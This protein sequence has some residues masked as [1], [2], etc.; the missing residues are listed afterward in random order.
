MSGKNLQD[1]SVVGLMS[2]GGIACLVLS[3]LLIGCGGGGGGSGS[4]NGGGSGGLI[5]ENSKASDDPL[6]QY[7]WH[8]KNNGQY[9]FSDT[10]PVAGFDLNIGD[11][12]AS[13]VTG[14]SVKVAVIDDGIEADHEN[15]KANMQPGGVLEFCEYPCKKE[16]YGGPSEGSKYHGTA[17]AGIVGSQRGNGVGGHGVAPDVKLYDFNYLELGSYVRREMEITK[18]IPP[19]PSPLLMIQAA[20]GDHDKAKSVDVFNM[21]YGSTPDKLGDISNMLRSYSDIMKKSRNDRGGVYVKSAGNE[22]LSIGKGKE[23]LE[24]C[25]RAVDNNVTC[26]NSNFQDIHNIPEVMVVG[27]V[28]AA[29]KRSSYSNTGSSIWISGFGGEYGHEEKYNPRANNIQ[30]QPAIVTTDLTSCHKGYNGVPTD[31]PLQNAMNAGFL[32]NF[33]EWG[34]KWGG[35]HLGRFCQYS[36]TF[37]GTSASAPMVSGVVA[38]MLEANNQLNARDVKWILATTARK[39]DVHLEPV[40]NQ[41]GIVLDQGWVENNVG[42]KFSNAYGFG[43]VDATNAVATARKHTILPEKEVID[44]VSSDDIVR[45]IPNVSSESSEGTHGI[46]VSNDLIIEHVQVRF[47]TNHARPADLRIVLTSPRGTKSFLM[48]PHSGL[49]ELE[50]LKPE[51][52][53]LM[54][55]NAFLGEKSQGRWQLQIVDVSKGGKASELKNWSIRIQGHKR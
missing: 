16:S 19:L 37:N 2:E 34:S 31:Y 17:V 20:L 11:L 47:H 5:D 22:F 55:S 51:F 54:S 28:N 1:E 21:S 4:G 49:V 39:V 29:G 6:F 53:G 36:A 10:R 48:S 43:L 42:H 38:L 24:R 3:L 33:Y 25:R 52:K 9:A 32:R 14:K 7:Q 26:M 27:A 8:L 50:G 18:K 40:K 30:K 44:W 46:E 15:L 12:H 35:R 45:S 23:G 41:D 13:G